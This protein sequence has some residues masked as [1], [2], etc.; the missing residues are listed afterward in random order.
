MNIEVTASAGTAS[1]RAPMTDSHQLV[2]AADAA[3]YEAKRG[4]RAQV[5]SADDPLPSPSEAAPR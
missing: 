4:G 5:R 2:Q 3:L 1:W